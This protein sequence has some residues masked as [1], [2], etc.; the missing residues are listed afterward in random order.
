MNVGLEENAISLGVAGQSTGTTAVNGAAI[1]TAGFDGVMI[2]ARI[3][4]A[5]AGNYLK[6]QQGNLSDSSDM[7]DLAGTKVVADAN[8]QLVVLDIFKPREQ[9]VRGVLIR[10][11]TTITGDMIYIRYHAAQQPQQN[12][13]VN[14]LKSL[15]VQSPAEG[16][17]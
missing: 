5:D 10:G 17:P 9:Y 11:V 8:G 2:I 4:T 15:K 13:I 12:T 7:A 14:V 6:A 16:A 1:D 3:A